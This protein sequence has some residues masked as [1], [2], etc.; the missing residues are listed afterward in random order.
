MVKRGASILPY[1]DDLG[2]P[3][4]GPN[5]EINSKMRKGT[6]L[7]FSKVL[8]AIKF[9]QTGFPDVKLTVR[10]VVA[11]PNVDFVHLIGETLKE[12]GIKPEKMRWKLYQVSPVGPRKMKY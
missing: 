12:N 9:V 4:D 11:E 3:L 1:I 6:I 5:T 10:T 7:H 8:E 2:L